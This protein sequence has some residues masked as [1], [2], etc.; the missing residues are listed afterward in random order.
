MPTL[1][2]V[3]K[4]VLLGL[5]KRKPHQ[6]QEKHVYG[7]TVP[8]DVIARRRAANRVARASRRVNRRRG[9]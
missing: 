6:A 9:R 2:D 8:D 4:V 1:K 3:E 5:Q 7:G